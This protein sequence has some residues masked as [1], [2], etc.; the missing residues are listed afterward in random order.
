MYSKWRLAVK[1][2]HYYFTASNGK[3][4]GIHSPFV[5][6]FITQV[7]NDKTHYSEYDVAEGLRQKMLNEQSVISVEDMGAGS[8]ASNKKDRTIVSI[9]QHA[10]KPGKFGQLLFR[11]VKKYQPRTMIELGTS[12]GITSSYLAL[13]KKDSNL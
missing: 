3:G 5:F 6:E 4:H 2:L 7:L 11:M 13:A 9:A 12:L 8:S 1:Y 10:A